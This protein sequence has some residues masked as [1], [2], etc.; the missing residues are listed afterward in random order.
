MAHAIEEID[1][2][3][4]HLQMPNR[5]QYR[6]D[7]APAGATKWTAGVLKGCLASLQKSLGPIVTEA[8]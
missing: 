6:P 4:D 3:A 8:F 2:K 1:D 7:S 5:S